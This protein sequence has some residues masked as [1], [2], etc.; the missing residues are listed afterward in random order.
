MSDEIA[1]APPKDETI[2]SSVFGAIPNT[3]LESPA[4]APTNAYRKLCLLLQ[5]TS[6]V[7]LSHGEAYN[8]RKHDAFHLEPITRS[9]SSA[10]A[11]NDFHHP[12]NPREE[13]CWRKRDHTSS[14][15]TDTIIIH[16]RHYTNERPDWYGPSTTF[17]ER[18]EG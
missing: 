5:P 14:K 7:I 6:G 12:T 13:V 1:Q 16:Y 9:R 3:H 15:C 2:S 17:T 18:R 4:T 10:I 11:G 8:T